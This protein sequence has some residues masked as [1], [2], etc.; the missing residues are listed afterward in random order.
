MALTSI[1]SA[2]PEMDFS[3][4][5]FLIID[6]FQGMRSILRDILRSCGAD[7][8]K[9]AA[10]ANGYE[11][12]KQ[13]VSER[14]DVVLCDFNLGPGKNGQQILEEAKLSTLIGPACA[15]IMV[16][17]EKTADAVTGAAEYQP[18]AYLL[19]P[20]TES[21]LRLRLAKIW[22]KKEAFAEIDQAMKR[23]DYPK[24]IGLC[25]KR[26]VFDKAN[27]TDLLRTKCDLLFLSGDLERARQVLEIILSERDIPW[28]KAG[29]AKVFFRT[30]EFAEAKAL[31]EETLRDNP[32]FLEAHDLLAKTLQA[33]G[34]LEGAAL[35]LERAAKLSPNSVIRQKNLGDVALKMGNLENAER[36]F[37]KSVNLGENSVLKSP[38]AYIGLAK[39]CSANANPEEAL[40]VLKKLTKS[41]DSEEVRL[42]SMAAEGLVHQQSGNTDKAKEIASNLGQ[43]IAA[44][45]VR[46]DSGSALEMARLMMVTGEI[47]RAVAL[48][49]SEVKN[50]PDNAALLS[51]VNEIFVQ[52]EMGDEGARL[53]ESSRREAT[54]LMNRGVLLARDGQYQEAIE[55]MR[56]ARQGMPTN[57][58]VMFNLAYVLITHMQKNGAMPE[59]VKEARASLLAGNALAP[60]VARFTQLTALLNELAASF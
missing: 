38:D 11:A 58:R 10:A 53:V 43:R 46:L 3:G 4:K 1:T 21:I 19:K 56:Y 40:K 18:D 9:I 50:S 12:I 13:L 45:G 39:T 32:S 37:R 7:V 14:F 35:A 52:A 20:I 28:A 51:E 47:D 57:V 27:A 44:S 2:S 33:Q 59:L 8:K 30:G 31:L 34:N 29:L 5:S 54:E 55:A 16:T 22:A 49:Q 60:G 25:D 48:L 24:A 23:L 36:A 17:A 6:D 15:W 42:K 26:L 41:F